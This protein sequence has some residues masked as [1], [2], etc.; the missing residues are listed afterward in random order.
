MDYYY[1]QPSY[2]L[3]V[4]DESY[5]LMAGSFE[6]GSMLVSLKMYFGYWT[7]LILFILSIFLFVFVESLHKKEIF[8]ISPII[9][10]LFYGTNLGITNF[11]ASPSFTVTLRF[12]LRYLPQSLLLFFILVTIYYFFF[13]EKK[14]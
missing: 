14:S 5:L 6:S 10:L 1:S 7:P 9:F 3:N 8:L 4:F 2:I 11:Y 12:V 13:A